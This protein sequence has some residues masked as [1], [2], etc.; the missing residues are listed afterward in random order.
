[1]ATPQVRETKWGELSALWRDQAN[2]AARERERGGVQGW[3]ARVYR[4]KKAEGGC[5]GTGGEE[6]ASVSG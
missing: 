5:G 2:K 1:M 6:K 3:V 4:N